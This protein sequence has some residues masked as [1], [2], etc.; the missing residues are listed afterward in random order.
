MKSRRKYTPPPTRPENTR[1]SG[2]KPAATTPARPT[3]RSPRFSRLLEA[4]LRWGIALLLLFLLIGSTSARQTA[5]KNAEQLAAEVA[6]LE[7]QR[8]DLRNELDLFSDPD[9][10][11]CYWK[12]RT[13]RHEPGEFFIDFMDPGIL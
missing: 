13:M 7:R 1:I 10:R 11:A 12:W 9:W 6:E 2:S 3:L 5:E 8:D 4:S